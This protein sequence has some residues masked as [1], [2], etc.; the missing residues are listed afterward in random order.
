MG[1]IPKKVPRVLYINRLIPSQS[2]PVDFT[3]GFE[4]CARL[5]FKHHHFV[6]GMSK[7][8]LWQNSIYVNMLF[9]HFYSPLI[10]LMI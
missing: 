9:A 6:F 10:E 2:T 8:D 1:C 7:T 5:P 3:L 4:E